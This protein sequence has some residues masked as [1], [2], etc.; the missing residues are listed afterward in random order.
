M[1]NNYLFSI[2]CTKT[3]DDRFELNK[4]YDAYYKKKEHKVVIFFDKG[5]E[6]SDSDVYFMDFP[7]HFHIDKFENNKD[8]IFLIYQKWHYDCVWKDYDWEFISN[9]NM[10][11]VE[12]L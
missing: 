4:I 11:L 9:K 7:P 10:L 5:I 2:K 1:K 12:L 6:M 8:L 3:Q